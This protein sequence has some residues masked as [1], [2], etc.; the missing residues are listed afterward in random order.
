MQKW[1]TKMPKLATSCSTFVVKTSSVFTFHANKKNA[2]VKA[3][4]KFIPVVIVGFKI[5]RLTF[6]ELSFTMP[7]VS[8]Q[9]I[10]WLM[11][12]ERKTTW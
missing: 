4:M 3:F 8:T 12:T 9:T 11:I 1:A 2:G 10:L 6:S 5:F 7:K